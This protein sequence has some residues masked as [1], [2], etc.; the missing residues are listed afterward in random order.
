MC[1]KQEWAS[2]I[3]NLTNAKFWIQRENYAAA[4]RSLKAAITH[5]SR[6][7]VKL[8]KRLARNL[9]TLQRLS[10]M[11]KYNY[12]R[13][14]APVQAIISKNQKGILEC[15]TVIS[16]LEGKPSV[17]EVEHIQDQLYVMVHTYGIKHAKNPKR[18]YALMG[19]YAAGKTP[20]IP[21]EYGQPTINA[22][23]V[24]RATQ[25]ASGKVVTCEKCG[26]TRVTRV[27]NPKKCPICGHV[28]NT[29]IIIRAEGSV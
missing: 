16:V 2:A 17:S 28:P 8:E 11:K 21:L 25:V 23:I 3:N 19:N 27:E 24:A 26:R 5:V 14:L 9:V 13:M 15:K 29:K 22:K 10:S 18:I 20:Q 1:W 7:Q 6:A 12:P 4:W